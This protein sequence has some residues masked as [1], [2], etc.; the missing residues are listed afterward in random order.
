MPSSSARGQSSSSFIPSPTMSKPATAKSSGAQ[1]ASTSSSSGHAP[2]SAAEKPP[3]STS[4][5]ESSKE[6]EKTNSDQSDF[7][8]SNSAP[9]SYRV[10]APIGTLLVAFGTFILSLYL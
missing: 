7:E 3:T 6:T 2:S 1:Q 10:S 9:S 5:T 8:F 4:A